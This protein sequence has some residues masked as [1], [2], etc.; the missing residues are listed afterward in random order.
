MPLVLLAITVFLLYA[1]ESSARTVREARIA[2]LK[3]NAEIAQA[4]AE[5]GFNRVRARIVGNAVYGATMS[6]DNT[7]VTLPSQATYT[8]DLTPLDPTNYAIHVKSTG[9]YGTGK[10]RTERVVSGS[11]QR[12][13]DPPYTPPRRTITTYD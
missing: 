8:L 2:T 9:V 10:L 13:N 12:D 11:I 3:T 7:S 4:A 5:A 6:L 1:A